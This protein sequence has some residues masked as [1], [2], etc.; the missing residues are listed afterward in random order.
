[1]RRGAYWGIRSDVGD[2]GLGDALEAPHEQTMLLAKIPT[3]LKTL[4]DS[5]QERLIKVNA[6]ARAPVE[7]SLEAG[8]RVPLSP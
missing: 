5:E 1:M 7:A 4:D 2:Y 8:G 3:R 6:P